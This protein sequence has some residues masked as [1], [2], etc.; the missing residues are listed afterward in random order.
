M[1]DIKK[2]NTVQKYIG[3]L[4][5][6][7]NTPNKEAEIIDLKKIIN[8]LF[9]NYN[10]VGFY[11]VYV[12]GS[13]P[14]INF[15]D[16]KNPDELIKKIDAKIIAANK[17]DD[18]D[19]EWEAESDE[20]GGIRYRKKTNHSEKKDKKPTKAEKAAA[21]EAKKAAEAAE[22]AEEA[23]KAAAAA[24]AAEEAKEAKKAAE[25]AEA[26]EEAKKAAAA[27]KAAEEAKKSAEAAEAAEE[28]KKAAAAA[29][30]AEEAKKAAEATKAAEEAQKAA[31]AAEAT[32]A[33]EEAKKAA[34]ERSPP[35]TQAELKAIEQAEIDSHFE[36]KKGVHK[37]QYL[38]DFRV[39]KKGGFK[40]IQINGGGPK[41]D[42][43]NIPIK[44]KKECSS[45]YHN[46]EIIKLL[47][48]NQTKIK[49]IYSIEEIQKLLV[50][51]V[52]WDITKLIELW[53]K[54]DAPIKDRYKEN[55]DSLIG[56]I[57]NNMKE[58]NKLI[59]NFDDLTNFVITDDLIKFYKKII[60]DYKVKSIDRAIA[61][62]LGFIF[63]DYMEWSEMKETFENITNYFKLTTKSLITN[64]YSEET[65][66][67]VL[68]YLRIRCD[69]IP[70]YNEYM[71]LYVEKKEK[72]QSLY[73]TGPDPNLKISLHNSEKPINGADALATLIPWTIEDGK[74]ETDPKIGTLKQFKAD[75][76]KYG[77]LYGPFT[78]TF[79]PK[80]NNVEIAAECSEVITRLNEGKSIFMPGVGTSGSG[81]TSAMI[82]LK[83]LDKSVT[84][85]VIKEEDGILLEILKNRSLLINPTITVSIHELFSTKLEEAT[86][87]P[88]KE[89][90]IKYDDIKFKKDRTGI[91]RIENP[92]KFGSYKQT[93]RLFNLVTKKIEWQLEKEYKWRIHNNTFYHSNYFKQGIE[94][95]TDALVQQL[96]AG[97]FNDFI[98]ITDL[99]TFIITI[100]DTLRMVYPT[101]NNNDSSRS[102]INIS[103]KVRDNVYLVFG[104]Y[105]GVEGKFLCNDPKTRKTFLN[106]KK[107]GETTNF[108]VDEEFKEFPPGEYTILD[109]FNYNKIEE[110]KDENIY[111][112][113]LQEKKT[114]IT[115][116][117]T[118]YK[119]YKESLKPVVPAGQAN[120][121]KSNPRSGP[122]SHLPIEPS[123]NRSKSV[124]PNKRH[125]RKLI[126]GVIESL[127]N[128]SLKRLNK[129]IEDCEKNL[130]SDYKEADILPK[131]IKLFNINKLFVKGTYKEHDPKSVR[132]NSSSSI[133][134][135]YKALREGLINPRENP[136]KTDRSYL[137]DVN[138]YIKN[139][140]NFNSSG[141][142]PELFIG[143]IPKSPDYYLFKNTTD[144]VKHDLPIYPYIINI[145]KTPAL[146]TPVTQTNE[147]LHTENYNIYS[148]FKSN[149]QFIPLITEL[150]AVIGTNNDYK[151]Y[152]FYIEEKNKLIEEKTKEQYSIK[153][154]LLYILNKLGL[155]SDKVYVDFLLAKTELDSKDLD[156]SLATIQMEYEMVYNRIM[157][158]ITLYF[159][160]IKERCEE[161]RAEGVLINRSLLGLR[162]ELINILKLQK[163]ESL[164][165]R[166]PLFNDSCLDCYCS[167]KS[168]NCFE[169]EEVHSTEDIQIIMKDIKEM[170][171]KDSPVGVDNTNNLSV[172][173]FGVIN[174]TQGRNDPPQTP[175]ID[176]KF[177]KDYRDEYY[178]KMTYDEINKE[179]VD[180]NKIKI[181]ELY[182]T[183]GKILEKYSENIGEPI[184]NNIGLKYTNFQGYNTDN[185]NKTSFQ[186]KFNFLKEFINSIEELNSLH[187]IGILDFMQSI[188]NY[189]QTDTTCNISDDTDFDPYINIVN[190]NRLDQDRKFR[191]EGR[192]IHQINKAGGATRMS[193][194]KKKL[195]QQYIKY[196]KE[197]YEL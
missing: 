132:N 157:L 156:G 110:I 56:T 173:I 150:E 125:E 152:K 55:Y 186:I 154:S 40:R 93:R 139:P 54:I 192:P 118:N 116:F 105:A 89:E 73:V 189:L 146:N 158:N 134:C 188:K 98:P 33:A 174:L 181:T 143:L 195:L 19:D 165:P 108:Y 121:A 25:A 30:A 81:K 169:K 36:R 11:P 184:I 128:S 92:N 130:K 65:N 117:F 32:K 58:I 34:A 138:N 196:T 44:W 31:E 99:G 5:D 145:N 170:I 67:P 41:E 194:N 140:S 18:L 12:P 50:L 2:K 175:Y 148:D 163:R 77:Y 91:F 45:Y 6:I 135:D 180:Q 167:D 87:N 47:S 24:K 133:M 172:A 119:L 83:Y 21:E 177:L 171:N 3:D 69:T 88:K 79:N 35:P 159:E 187:N 52:Y 48:L 37:Y 22:A 122:L 90:P 46:K 84:P 112:I 80:Q 71:N 147:K 161:R 8:E 85:P 29:K 113:Q 95:T 111:K 136:D 182:T 137:I 57:S 197:L 15:V 78:K 4:V 166:F 101:P 120:R 49:Q 7:I 153:Y 53:K 124:A 66:E 107:T 68:T 70:D 20:K 176:L 178:T 38:I 179:F 151:D 129:L 114:E 100:V 62:L 63:K 193:S 190:G 10:I 64:A 104:D 28:A 168:F 42:L 94:K 96:N 126:G 102:H 76:F 97:L 13:P 191:N 115:E 23:K 155:I 162:K 9:K 51:L 43:F 27:A 106:L 72:F 59:S 142:K 60:D 61:P 183:I 144:T 131:L 14:S 16:P 109:Y 141:Y 39:S 17:E 75:A 149:D 82:K 123:G 127:Y 86:G 164:F 1:S 103:I 185:S 74:P 160:K 26:A